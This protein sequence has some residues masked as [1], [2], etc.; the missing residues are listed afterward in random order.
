MKP[1]QHFNSNREEVNAELDCPPAFPPPLLFLP[2]GGFK[3]SSSPTPS[4]K[5]IPKE[6][7]AEA[8]SQTSLPA[9]SSLR[10]RVVCL[11]ISKEILFAQKTLR[12]ALAFRS[13]PPW[14]NPGK[15]VSPCNRTGN[16]LENFKRKIIPWPHHKR[17]DFGKSGVNLSIYI[18]FLAPQG[19]LFCFGFCLLSF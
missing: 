4:T 16:H 19:I 7:F 9:Q 8:Q 10:C 14:G 1:R 5:I 2:P 17:A 13:L 3:P 18:F 12:K 15:I 11:S 6:A